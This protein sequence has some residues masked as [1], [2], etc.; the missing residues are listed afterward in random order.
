MGLERGRIEI[1]KLFA[2]I[3][4]RSSDSTSLR[5]FDI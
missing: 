3:E 5:L 2:A 4:R 1:E